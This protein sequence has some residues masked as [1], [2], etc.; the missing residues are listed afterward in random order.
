MRPDPEIKKKL[1]KLF[2]PDPI[3]S[4]PIGPDWARFPWIRTY[5][6]VTKVVKV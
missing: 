6:E 2:K 5:P 1:F 3:G 4:D